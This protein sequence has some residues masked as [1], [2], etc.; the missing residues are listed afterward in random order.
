[1]INIRFAYLAMIII[2]ASCNYLV[3]FPINDW[4][5]YGSFTYP[6]SFLITEL[7]NCFHGPKQAR[8]VVYV[9]FILAVLLS[10]WLVSPKIAFASGF[11]FLISQ[12]LDISVFNKMRRS[13]WWYAPLFASISASLI[14]TLI[15]WNFAFFGEDLPYLTWAMGDFSI[16]VLF[17]FVLLLPFRLAIRKQISPAKT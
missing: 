13:T 16:K 6:L 14:D 7:T 1:M 17:D 10:I 2:V 12:L 9:G 11:A 5:T 3:Q 4:L 15:F 8:R